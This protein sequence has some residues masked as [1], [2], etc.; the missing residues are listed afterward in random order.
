MQKWIVQ[1]ATPILCGLAL[2]LGV[3]ALGRGARAALHD[4]AGYT[5]AFHEIDCEPPQG[6]SRGA[7]LDE[8]RHLSRQTEMLHLLDE[9]ATARLARAF[10]A[11]P[12]VESVRRVQI[13]RRDRRDAGLRVELTYRQP[14][15][16]VWLPSDKAPRGGNALMS[17][18]A[19]DRQGVLL[20]VSA[21]HTRLPV[22]MADVSVPAGSVGS[23]W[24]DRRVWAAAAT[25]AFLK[26]HLVRLHLDDC[27]IEVVGGEVVFR[28]PGVRVVWGHAP[29][30]EGAGEAPAEVKLRRLLDYQANH[31][32]LGSLEH[33]VRLIAYQGHFPLTPDIQP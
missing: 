15:L 24:G 12:W 7:F 1:T 30:H 9:D 33:D 14:V 20:P 28:K 21:V 29:G 32:G 10:A 31:D 13:V 4:R 11:H 25:V 23:R 6:M 22:L 26:P 8:V 16:A 18:R 17:A 27:D 3:I 19:V 5:V 2:L